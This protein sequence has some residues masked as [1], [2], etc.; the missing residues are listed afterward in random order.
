MSPTADMNVLIDML[1]ARV[2]ASVLS[3]LKNM[4][5]APMRSEKILLLE[6]SCPP[7]T[8]APQVVRT[9]KAPPPRKPQV[10]EDNL[11]WNDFLPSSRLAKIAIEFGDIPV[12]LRD[13]LRPNIEA[14]RKPR[15]G[16]YPTDTTTG[17]EL[18]RYTYLQGGRQYDSESRSEFAGQLY[19]DGKLVRICLTNHSVV[20]ALMVAAALV[21]PRLHSMRSAYAWMSRIVE[22]GDPAVDEWLASVTLAPRPPTRGR[23]GRTSRRTVMQQ[24]C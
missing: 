23:G 4:F 20:A 8:R 12:K 13:A 19:M 21:D 24:Q 17:Q 18:Y 22:Q 2:T 9:V 5:S 1:T 7:P 11:P 14:L 10:N 3:E 15:D 16:L 6:N